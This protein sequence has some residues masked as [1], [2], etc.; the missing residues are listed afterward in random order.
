[1]VGHTLRH[2]EELHSTILEGMVEE[3]NYMDVLTTL[4]L[5]KS[6]SRKVGSYIALKEITSDRKE[7]RRRV[8]NQSTG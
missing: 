3:K 8:A 6:K 2:S 7:W 1:M 5:D 4:L